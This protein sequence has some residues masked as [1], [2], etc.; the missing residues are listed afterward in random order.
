VDCHQTPWLP[1]MDRNHYHRNLFAG[2]DSAPE[3]PDTGWLLVA[4]RDEPE[5]ML[6][7]I[8]W[9]WL[10]AVGLDRSTPYRGVVVV[11]R[12]GETPIIATQPDRGEAV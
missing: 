4:D 3:V 10:E 7:G 6:G 11:S 2:L 9:T 5:P 12:G 8:A 1:L